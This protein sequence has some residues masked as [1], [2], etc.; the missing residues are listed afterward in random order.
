M[1]SALSGVSCVSA[2]LCTV[3]GSATDMTGAT[4]ALV[5]QWD[6]T[7]WQVQDAPSPV[8]P[9]AI[10]CTSRSSC[11]AVGTSSPAGVQ[12]AA[13]EHWNG[14]DW[15]PQQMPAIS[16][17]SGYLTRV[18]CYRGA[19]T[20]VGVSSDGSLVERWNGVGWTIEPTPATDNLND[21]S[22]PSASVCTAT[23]ALVE[24]WDGTSWTVQTTATLP[25]GAVGQDFNGVDCTTKTA[26][27]AV[28][29]A[30]HVAHGQEY[31]RPLAES[32]NG[33]TWTLQHA[34][35]PSGAFSSE[36]NAVTCAS[37][38]ACAAVGDDIDAAGTDVPLAEAWNGTQWAIRTV[39]VSSDVSHS[40]LDSVSCGA[41]NACV[42]V[43]S[44]T[45]GTT[46]DP[47]AERWDREDL[48]G[49]PDRSNPD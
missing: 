26:C 1:T 37:T 25:T 36:L 31:D 19:C 22:C 14:Q 28:G 11:L 17:V 5:E 9:S 4:A 23:G 40:E 39:S 6:G 24:R 47:I 49:H 7:G 29:A 41:A 21:V 20:A 15:T 27:E 46:N 45:S 32:W 33:T 16:T 3:T 35:N 30:I 48:D 2:T 18:S 43:G 13:A 44:S 34:P 8:S 10:S 38:V 42:A 12:V